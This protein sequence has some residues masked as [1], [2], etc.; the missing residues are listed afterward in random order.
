MQY[1]GNW[2]GKKEAAA[3]RSGYKKAESCCSGSTGGLAS[4]FLTDAVL[5]MSWG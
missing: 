2:S 5:N 4:V 3:V 1:L